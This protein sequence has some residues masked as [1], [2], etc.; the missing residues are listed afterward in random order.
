MH[1]YSDDNIEGQ[2]VPET[3]FVFFPY[4][5]QKTIHSAYRHS[6][7]H[8]LRVLAMRGQRMG[9]FQKHHQRLEMQQERSRDHI[10]HRL[11]A[12]PRLQ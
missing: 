4:L 11:S 5:E 9:L 12:M 2:F 10:I 6:Y 1:T 3:L 7:Q 8:V